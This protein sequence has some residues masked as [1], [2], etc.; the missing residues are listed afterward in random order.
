LAARPVLIFFLFF[1]AYLFRAHRGAFRTTWA[2]IVLFWLVMAIVAAPLVVFLSANPGAEI[3]ISEV[4]APLRAFM[5]GDPRQVL[6]NALKIAAMFGLSGDP[7]WRQNV[8]GRP[9]FD[10]LMGVMF[11]IGVAYSLW[12]W[13][14]PRH[15]F[16]TLWLITSAIPSLVTIDAPSSIRII[17]LLPTL[18]LF[19]L[20]LIHRV[21]Y[22]STFR[23]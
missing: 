12:R 3:R 10:P 19:P 9:V 17:N 8:D 16:L 14:D 1:A 13:R 20:V 18:M 2:G 4:D 6:E 7:L 22:L 11:Y 21:P 5:Q 15:T 23:D